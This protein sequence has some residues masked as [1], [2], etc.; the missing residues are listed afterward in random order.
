[1]MRVSHSTTETVGAKAFLI[2]NERNKTILYEHLNPTR[3]LI[4][5]IKPGVSSLFPPRY[6][7]RGNVGTAMGEAQEFGTGS[8]MDFKT[9]KHWTGLALRFLLASLTVLRKHVANIP[10]QIEIRVRDGQAYIHMY[11]T[12][13]HMVSSTDGFGVLS[14]DGTMHRPQ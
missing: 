4:N 2:T 14:L 3:N 1:M 9:S 12:C 13:Q 5:C 7:A 6:R 8:E 10:K 11:R